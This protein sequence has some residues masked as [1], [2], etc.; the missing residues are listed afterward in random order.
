MKMP[1]PIKSFHIPD[2]WTPEQALAAYELLSELSDIVW[3]AHHEAI[4]E[5]YQQHTPPEPEYDDD[6]E[7]EH[8]LDDDI[9][10]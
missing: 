7:P 8:D 6:A 1:T 10:F 9:P 3:D 2:D 5:L 4:I